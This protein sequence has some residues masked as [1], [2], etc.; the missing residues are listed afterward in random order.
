MAVVILAML[1]AESDQF[2]IQELPESFT[3]KMRRSPTAGPCEGTVPE[4]EVAEVP[5]E[6]LW[7]SQC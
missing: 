5:P 7:I 6:T 3:G 2:M 4:T 1:G